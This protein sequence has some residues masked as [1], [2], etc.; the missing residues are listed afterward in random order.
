MNPSCLALLGTIYGKKKGP[1][2]I[3]SFYIYIYTYV[4]VCLFRL[5]KSKPHLLRTFTY[6]PLVLLFSRLSDGHGLLAK[7]HFLW[8]FHPRNLFEKTRSVPINGLING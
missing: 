5:Y 7:V 1:V 3:L 4:Y 2:F 6:S 8:F